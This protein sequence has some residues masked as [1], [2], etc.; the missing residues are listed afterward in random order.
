[1]NG[2]G[3]SHNK[4]ELYIP[5]PCVH[6]KNKKKMCAFGIMLYICD[7]AI[8]STPVGPILRLHGSKKLKMLFIFNSSKNGIIMMNCTYLMYFLSFISLHLQIYY[9]PYM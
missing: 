1:M 3:H 4:S 6:F 9:C 5:W 7:S 2:E 8:S